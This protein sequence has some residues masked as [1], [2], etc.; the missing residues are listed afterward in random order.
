MIFL[1][2]LSHH[3]FFSLALKKKSLIIMPEIAVGAK[4]GHT[5]TKRTVARRPSQTRGVRN[6]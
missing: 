6:Q 4:K 1:N 5:V 2:L 3:N